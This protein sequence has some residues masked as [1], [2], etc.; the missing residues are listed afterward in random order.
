MSSGCYATLTVTV[1]SGPAPIGGLLRVCVNGTTI[2]TDAGSGGTWT[3][4]APS[5][6]TIGSSSGLLAGVLSGTVT[7]T[8]SLGTGCT[9]TTYVTVNPL[10]GAI[11]GPSS[12]CVGQ[13]G[14][15]SDG[16][17]S[18]IW[19][20][21]N[22]TIAT[23]GSSSG[24]LSGMSAG[25]A[26]ISYT[27]PTGCAATR[28]ETINPGPATI[29]GTARVCVGATSTLIDVTTG[30]LWNCSPTTIATVG[31][32]TGIVT[33]VMAGIATITYTI[34]ESGCIAT[35][36]V[37]VNSLP[38]PITGAGMLCIGAT[39]TLSDALPGGV[40]SSGATGIA[41]VGSSSGIV[42]G[43]SAGTAV[44][45]YSSSAGC[46]VTKMVTV[47][48]LPPGIAGTS[49]VCIGTSAILSDAVTGGIWT[50]S[51]TMI[52]TIGSVTGIVTG[53]NTGSATITYSLGA[54]CFSTK[55]ISVNAAPPSITGSNHVCAGAA[56]TL[57][58]F[59]TGGTWSSGLPGIATIGS[60]SG[61]VTGVS[62]GSATI[63]Y[64]VPMGC[65]VTYN[66]TVNSVPV[67]TGL[68]T[69]C[70]WGDTLTVY[71][72]DHTG[73]YSSTV[74]TV[75]NLGGGAGRI[76]TFAPGTSTVTYT[77]PSGCTATESFIVNP[78]PGL[79]TGST[80]VCAGAATTLHNTTAGGVWSSAA[81][82][83]AT[84]GSGSGI[85]SGVSS[86]ATY[87]SYILPTGCKVDTL[88]H[89]NPP[90]PMIIGYPTMVAG[91]TTPYSDGTTGGLWGSSNTALATIGIS[92]GIANGISAGV[93]TFTYTIGTGCF[94]TKNVTVNPLTGV[95]PEGVEETVITNGDIIVLPNPNKG[96]FILRI[97]EDA[98]S[99]TEESWFGITDMLGRLVYQD[100]ITS[101]KGLIEERILLGDK[102]ANGMYLM[103]VHCRMG[104]KVLHI[105][106]SR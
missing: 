51:N 65:I 77:L 75:L 50:S 90:P 34:T 88:V 16:T 85:V 78:L 82:A 24:I 58:D 12:V 72:A 104:I 25:I 30:G 66:V 54:G 60:L 14:A 57:S 26:T 32:G 98:I 39:S 63:S 71:D 9:V 43:V 53:V 61:I 27:L 81:P 17:V 41:T 46:T 5:T 95:S 38:G 10:P 28:T 1:N 31:T 59:S 105:E 106:V 40:W 2:L 99:P 76:T 35:L 89:V 44:I 74:A 68:T 87:I 49:T 103:S 48:S 22:T 47:S 62:G 52:A 13:T 73:S 11:S 96:E 15:E 55:V 33:G 42:T 56:I 93:V 101:Q 20:S 84:V 23:I 91:T 21:S 3:S 80:N 102:I 45:T 69:L 6:A 19:S 70:A 7:V 37:T 92:T 29:T 94:A 18:G 100:K 79:I 83:V 36:P 64:T 97:N 67:I 86:G 8:Y 4:S